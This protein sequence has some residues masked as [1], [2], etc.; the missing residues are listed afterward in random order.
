MSMPIIP[1]ANFSLA[2]KQAHIMASVPPQVHP[3]VSPRPTEQIKVARQ[4]S[5]GIDH[6]DGAVTKNVESSRERPQGSP[7]RFKPSPILYI[8][9]NITLIW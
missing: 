2:R 7:G 3:S 4:V 8:E 9:L 1:R 5:R 6:K